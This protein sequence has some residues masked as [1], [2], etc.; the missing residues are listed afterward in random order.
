MC[1]LLQTALQAW[2]MLFGMT[3]LIEADFFDKKL[4]LSKLIAKIILF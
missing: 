4:Q 2:I 3:F 1:F